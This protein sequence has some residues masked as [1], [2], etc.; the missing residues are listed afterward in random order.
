[1][2]VFMEKYN[3]LYVDHATD[4]AGGQMS[5]LTRI[6]YLNRDKF[7]P[8]VLLDKNNQELE[9]RLIK[10]N[11]EF[12]KINFNRNQSYEGK[13]YKQPI[14]LLKNIPLVINITSK[15][16]KIVKEYD[17]DLIHANTFKSALICNIVTLYFDIPIL[18]HARSSKALSN[19]GYLDFFVFNFSDLIIANSEFTKDTFGKWEDKI[20]VIYSGLDLEEF[21]LNKTEK[22]FNSKNSIIGFI[23]RISPRKRLLDFINA[24]PLILEENNSVKFV[25]VGDIEAGSE[26]Y[27]DKAKKEIEK[28]NIEDRIEFLGFR[29][30]IP[31]IINSIDILIFPSINEPLGRVVMESLVLKTPVI[32]ANSGGVK[33]IIENN[34]SGILTEPK[35]YEEIAEKSIYLLKNNEFA[36]EMSEYGMKQVMKKFSAKR[37]TALEEKLY[38]NVLNLHI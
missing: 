13:I 33:E 38:L 18:Y 8:I 28:L 4:I 19:H 29:D 16:T 2:E 5:L 15:I 26:K 36:K 9:K 11:T 17:I 31:N 24:I 14:R 34:K 3:I 21:K 37:I 32:A 10:L 30:D 23:S 12:I 20:K 27:F 1:M 35:N 22:I 6:K 7:R 25:V